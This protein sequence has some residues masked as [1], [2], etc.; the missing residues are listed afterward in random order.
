MSKET[1]PAE[2]LENDLREA[3]YAQELDHSLIV[4]FCPLCGSPLSVL[5]DFCTAYSCGSTW[6]VDRPPDQ[7][8]ECKMRNAAA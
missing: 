1:T 2:R 4:D 8:E 7:T 6:H 5:S 3:E